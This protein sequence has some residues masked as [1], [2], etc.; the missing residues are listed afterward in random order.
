[1]RVTITDKQHI[2]LEEITART[3]NDVPT[4]INTAILIYA[5]FLDMDVDSKVIPSKKRFSKLE[6]LTKVADS[7]MKIVEYMKNS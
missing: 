3:S 6:I 4:I 2:L 5:Q 7:N 1:M